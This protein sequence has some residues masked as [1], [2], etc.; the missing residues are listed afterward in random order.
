MN[1]LN[2]GKPVDFNLIQDYEQAA[3]DF[4]EGSKELEILL[5]NCF[6][7]RI[8]TISCCA[9]HSDE[10]KRKPYISFL[11]SQENEQYI[12]AIIS[13]LK[14]RG[15]NFRYI[16]SEN[17]SF[18]NI[19][20]GVNFDF[21]YSSTMFS[22]INSVI[23]D[24]DKEKDYYV[25]LPKDLQKFCSIIRASDYDVFLKIDGTLNYFQMCYELTP[26]GYEYSMVISDSYYNNI[27]EKQN[28]TKVDGI[29]PYYS[30]KVPNR[31]M[32]IQGLNEFVSNI[33]IFSAKKDS[34][35]NSIQTEPNEENSVELEIEFEYDEKINSNLLINNLKVNLGDSLEIVA[36]KLK[37]C[38]DKGINAFAI[39]NGIELNNYNITDSYQIIEQYNFQNQLLREQHELSKKNR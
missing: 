4:A 26:E 35:S 15:Y 24:F 16:K 23:N 9:G 14:D 11:Y 10:N 19:Q 39:F 21:S 31:E 27:A 8:N 36:K 29:V 13:K 32:A 2:T 28:F 25:E 7:K 5:L 33:Q 37:A 18:V 34:L 6:N 12:Y 38:R 30:L 20:E 1:N 22:E 17:K 3:R